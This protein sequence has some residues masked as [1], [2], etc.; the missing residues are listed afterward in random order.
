[1][2]APAR[3]AGKCASL[4]AL[5]QLEA[6]LTLNGLVAAEG[7]QTLPVANIGFRARLQPSGAASIQVPI[8]LDNGGRRSD[9]E[10]GLELSPL[11][12][13]YSV[14]GRLTGQQVELEDL[15]GV[16]SVFLASAAPETADQPL[17]PAQVVPD[18]VAAWDRFSGRLALD[19]KS[20][21]RGQDWA[22][23]G[24]TGAVAIEPSVVTLQKLT[25]AFS[26]T[27]RLDAKMELRFTGGA[28]PYRL[29]GEY[30]LNDFD[31]GRLFKAID[32]SRPPTV[33][34]LFNI[35]GRLAGNGETMSRAVD[36][37]TG[38]FQLTSRGG[39]FRGLQRAS[40][41][42]SMTSKAVELGASVLGSIFGS[43][44]VVKTAEKVAGQAYFVDQ[45]AAGIGEFKYDLLS[46]RL[47]R[48]EL[49]NMNLEDIS[50]VSPEIRLSGRGSV[51]YVIGRPLL[52]QPL[53]ASL[54]FAARGKMEQLFA[55][56]RL[57]DGTKDE[58]GYS[59]TREPITLAGT[60]AKP[61]PTAF[62]T[63][64]ATAKLADFLD[65]DN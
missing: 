45:L 53:T 4:G 22:M 65:A 18:A 47:A 63:K 24:L 49:L 38:Q 56:A 54:S 31:T 55:K 6:R 27:S 20:I 3:P 25:A 50:L 46:V 8:L 43:D 28:M 33:E 35:S 26:A 37:V 64:I 41:K 7:T 15:L 29:V 14:D 61:D 23:T 5:S 12:R 30:A 9:L 44:K 13:G 16:L 36:R 48:D 58:L 62:F 21:T 40:N 57:L 17:A 39:V 52:E 60:L 51:S 10:F 34:G 1:M 32:P 19:V 42:V 2:S 11:G 59:R